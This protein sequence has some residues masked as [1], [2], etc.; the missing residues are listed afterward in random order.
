MDDGATLLAGLGLSV[1]SYGAGG[2]LSLSRRPKKETLQADIL[3]PLTEEDLVKVSVDVGKPLPVKTLQELKQSHHMLARVM[4]SG[5]YRGDA[6]VATITGFSVQRITMLKNDPAFAELLAYYSDMEEEQHTLATANMHTRLAALGFDAIETLHNKLHDEP[7]SFNVK[8]LLA[9][10]EA[11]SD[12][13]GHGKTS[14]VN[15]NVSLSLDE[16]ALTR[17]REASAGQA[18]LAEADRRGLLLLATRRTAEVS[19]EAVDA[20]WSEAEGDLLREE[21]DQRAE[22][23]EVGDG[24]Q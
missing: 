21:G 2:G 23:Q 20:T 1:Q 9:I 12:R 22:G 8:T 4:A 18:P 19:A 24:H 15:T 11:I 10:V 3:R 17:I 16:G 6:E 5:V 7:D 13:T 14:T